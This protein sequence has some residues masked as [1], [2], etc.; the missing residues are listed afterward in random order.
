MDNI[1]YLL[2]NSNSSMQ[3]ILDVTIYMKNISDFGKMNEV[4]KEYFKEGE[5]PARVTVQ[6]ISPIESIDIE[7]K[8]VALTN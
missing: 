2:E 3:N 4:Y 6:A 5:A 8:V 7:I 1:K